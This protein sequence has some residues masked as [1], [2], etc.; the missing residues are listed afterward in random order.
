MALAVTKRSDPK[1]GEVVVLATE[2]DTASLKTLCESVLP[3]YWIPRVYVHVEAL[4][5]TE[6]GKIAR[7]KLFEMVGGK[8]SGKVVG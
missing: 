7:K 2:G 6:T 1:F 5:K 3:K 8:E 4:P